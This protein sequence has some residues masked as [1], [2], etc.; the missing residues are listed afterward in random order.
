MDV[1]CGK[2][3]KIIIGRHG[4]IANELIRVLESRGEEFISTSRKEEKD[5]I[6]KLDLRKPEADFYSRAPR[7]SLVYMLASISSPEMCSKEPEFARIVNV[8]ATCSFIDN[9]LIKGLRVCF[10]STDAIFGLNQGTCFDETTAHPLGP[11]AEMKAEVERHFLPYKEFKTVRFSYVLSGHD[12]F[13]LYLKECAEKRQVAL[14]YDP[15]IRSVIGLQDVVIGLIN[16]DKKWSEMPSAINFCG[17]EVV[18][19]KALAMAF[20]KTYESSLEFKITEAPNSFFKERARTI[21]TESTYFSRLLGKSTST[22]EETYS[23]YL[24]LEKNE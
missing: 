19:R 11:S 6:L 12:K 1:D 9:C 21:I 18:S 8:D 24:N 20:K 2:P 3:V 17:R 16:L 7:G 15:F 14:I 10:A 23:Y 13:S 5:G 4:Y 22:I